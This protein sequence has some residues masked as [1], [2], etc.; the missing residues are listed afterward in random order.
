VLN[1]I[2]IFNAFKFPEIGINI[3]D[4]GQERTEEGQNLA[5]LA[6]GTRK[7]LDTVPDSFPFCSFENAIEYS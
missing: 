6:R 3:A 2:F 4:Q 1:K 7:V 5:D